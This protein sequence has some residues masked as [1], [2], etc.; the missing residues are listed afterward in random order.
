MPAINISLMVQFAQ[1]RFQV[2]SLPQGT[3]R[4]RFANYIRN[5]CTAIGQGLEPWRLQA[6]L[7]G[8]RIV[9]ATASGG[10]LYSSVGIETQV[11]QRAPTGWDNYTQ[12]IAA[13]V[14]NQFQSFANE[15]SVPGLAWYPAFAAWPG[16]QAPPMPNVP[17]PLMAIS[18][19]A[20]RH[21]R[22]SAFTDMIWNKLPS[23]KPPC[24][25]EVAIAIG[26]GLEKAAF[27][28]LSAQQVMN[29]LGKGPVPGFAPPYVPV[30]PVMGGDIIST[31][32]HIAS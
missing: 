27:A 10:K 25:K 14:H 24:G 5:M 18:A 28:W 4:T 2:M 6:R 11:R 22:E 1:Q 16:P 17:C 19:M 23:P 8:V 30:G 32:G 21:L 7:T 31:A 9:A 15:V 20:L 13:G 3:D 26:H 29:V 12:A